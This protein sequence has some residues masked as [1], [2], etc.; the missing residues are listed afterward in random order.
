MDTQLLNLLNY[1]WKSRTNGIYCRQSTKKAP[2]GAPG[3]YQEPP[4]GGARGDRATLVRRVYFLPF[5]LF[6]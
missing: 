2:G 6:L 1:Y 5:S 4:L 3:L